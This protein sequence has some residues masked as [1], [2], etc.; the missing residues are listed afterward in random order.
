MK[1]NQQ[2]QQQQ[3]SCSL[4][5]CFV[6]EL[7]SV[8]FVNK[9]CQ[10]VYSKGRIPTAPPSLIPPLRRLTGSQWNGGRALEWRG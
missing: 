1:V 7:Q 8:I 6:V 5:G 4:R 10:V 2:Q 3:T 9:R